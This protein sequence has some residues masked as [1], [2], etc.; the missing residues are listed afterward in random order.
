MAPQWLWLDLLAVLVVA[1][2]RDSLLNVC[3]DAKHHKQAPGR[4]DG[5]HE[6]C[7]P[8][9][10]NACCT[11]NTSH[12]AHQDQSYLY[13][14]NWN[15]CGSMSERCKKHF[16]QDTCLYE[17][18]PNLGP[19]INQA[20]TSWRQERILNVPLCKEDCEMWWEDCK[21]DMTCKENWH[22]GWNWTTG[23]NQCPRGSMCLAMKFVFPEP[24]DLCEKIW[25][26]SYQ[27]TT[28]QKGSG[29]CI[30]MWFNST[31]GNPN[32]AVAKYYSRA[33]RDFAACLPLALLFPVLLVLQ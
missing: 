16:I 12:A 8:W 6:Q 20:D 30:Q 15:H 32:V 27:Y 7:S 24:K 19:W 26:N 17:C 29:R 14:F 23:T 18:S 22:K 11:L 5:L 33:R 25:T 1:A 3:M 21:E 13:N 28:F 4:E 9:K 10:D 31:Q 2:E